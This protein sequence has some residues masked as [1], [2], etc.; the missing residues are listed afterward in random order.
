[1]TD[2]SRE[3][4][5]ELIVANDERLEEEELPGGNYNEAYHL[6]KISAALR[7]LLNPWKGIES[8]KI[9]DLIKR[10]Q[11]TSEALIVGASRSDAYDAEMLRADADLFCELADALRIFHPPFPE[12]TE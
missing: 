3:Q 8:A 6:F 12:S 1:M 10:A 7:Q 9:E 5:E 2:L 11:Q 4:I